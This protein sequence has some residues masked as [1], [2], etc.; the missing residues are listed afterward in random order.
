MGRQRAY[1]VTPII[2]NVKFKPTRRFP[3]VDEAP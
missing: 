2:R 1:L 3:P